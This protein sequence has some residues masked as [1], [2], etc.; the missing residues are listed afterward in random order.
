MR[1]ISLRYDEIYYNLS[2][3]VYSDHLKCAHFIQQ[4]CKAVVSVHAWNAKRTN[5][6]TKWAI[7]RG[8]RNIE[9]VSSKQG[10]LQF[11]EKTSLSRNVPKVAVVWT[12]TSKFFLV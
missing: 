12:G 1:F 10:N 5:V 9:F 8:F 7:K 3:V 2:S 6:N 11:L 4:K